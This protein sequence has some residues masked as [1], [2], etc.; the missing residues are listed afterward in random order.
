LP[1]SRLKSS[2]PEPVDQ[3][4]G[5]PDDTR[6]P[7]TSSTIT[8]AQSVFKFAQDTYL[9]YR[10]D[11]AMRLGAGLAYYGLFAAVPMVVISLLLAN[12]VFTAAEVQAV[13]EDFLQT[14]TG[15]T[16]PELAA[17]IASW[18]NGSATADGLGVIAVAT[19]LYTLL[20]AFAALH[21]CLNVI[22]G[23]PH[24]PDFK[25]F[26]HRYG[27]AF[28][29]MLPITTV[30]LLAVGSQV[31]AQTVIEKIPGNGGLTSFALVAVQAASIL[32][33]V[34]GGFTFLYRFLPDATPN[35][36]ASTIGG[37]VATGLT[38]LATTALAYYF[39]VFFEISVTGTA[40]AMIASLVWLYYQAQVL[41]IGAEVTKLLTRGS[42]Y[43]F[44]RQTK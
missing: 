31:A 10:A 24:R 7:L 12:A 44:N 2:D 42:L 38:W 13:V 16:Q 43:E 4:A 26:V 41:L 6:P 19:L 33:I 27:K 15:E 40:S 9:E 8:S 3:P 1:D 5:D 11:R 22:W 30:V 21:D 39:Q 14:A 35:L 20:L 36:R 28:A 17:E 25:G 37:L 18:L 29:A 23:A 32:A 34:V